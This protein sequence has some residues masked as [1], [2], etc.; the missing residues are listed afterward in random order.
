M[1]ALLLR[2]LRFLGTFFHLPLINPNSKSFLV[3]DAL[4]YSQLVEASQTKIAEINLRICLHPPQMALVHP[5]RDRCKCVSP[6]KPTSNTGTMLFPEKYAGLH[7]SNPP[8]SPS[9]LSHSLP[10]PPVT[11]CDTQGNCVVSHEAENSADASASC[12]GI[13][14][15]GLRFLSSW[16][17]GTQHNC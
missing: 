9:S 6:C 5:W 2:N 11:T 10:F 3:Q 14:S 1:R 13:Y 16:R 4:V 7:G 8:D 15:S 17:Q 12:S